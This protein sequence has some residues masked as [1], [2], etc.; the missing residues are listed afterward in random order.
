[1]L[2]DLVGGH[3]TKLDSLSSQGTREG[4]LRQVEGCL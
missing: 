4:K 2:R 1:M 3:T